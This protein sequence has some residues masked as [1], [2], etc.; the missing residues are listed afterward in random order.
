MD[1]RPLG[2]GMSCVAVAMPHA[3]LEEGTTDAAPGLR[4]IYTA[5]RKHNSE[6]AGGLAM[7]CLS[8]QTT[9]LARLSGGSRIRRNA[10]REKGGWATSERAL[11]SKGMKDGTRL[12]RAGQLPGKRLKVRR[13]KRCRCLFQHC[14]SASVETLSAGGVKLAYP[15]AATAAN[16]LARPCT[17]ARLQHLSVHHHHHLAQQTNRRPGTC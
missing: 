4:R 6:R 14:D 3:G 1:F 15:A 12:I 9:M 2:D 7:G 5:A 16:M 8:I 10:R 17:M 11:A 13:V